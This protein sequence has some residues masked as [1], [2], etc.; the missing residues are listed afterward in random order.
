ME[1]LVNYNLLKFILNY[2]KKKNKFQFKG[3]ELGQFQEYNLGPND[4]LTPETQSKRYLIIIYKSEPSFRP[5][6]KFQQQQQQQHAVHHH[7]W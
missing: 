5:P 4:N 2:K 6:D 7:Q 1:T 3:S